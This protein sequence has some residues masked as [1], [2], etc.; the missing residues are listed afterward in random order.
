MAKSKATEENKK[1]EEKKK[2]KYNLWQNALYTLSGMWAMDR[3]L[4]LMLALDVIFGGL[5]PLPL[6]LLPKFV[7]DEVTIG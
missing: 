4:F 6:L 7:L 5:L 3:P 2:P 1:T